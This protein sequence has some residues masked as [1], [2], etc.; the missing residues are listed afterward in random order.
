MAAKRHPLP[1]ETQQVRQIIEGRTHMEAETTIEDL[2]KKTS[3]VVSYI[4]AHITIP[5]I[6]NILSI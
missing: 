4:Q 2:F 3:P 6:T 1:I 5:W